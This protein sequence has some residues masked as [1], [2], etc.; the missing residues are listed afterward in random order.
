M[1]VAY[2]HVTITRKKSETKELEALYKHRLVIWRKQPAIHRVETP[3]NLVRARTL[4]Y[5]AKQGFIMIRV[6]VRR[7]GL[8]RPRPRMGRRQT[9][10][11][12]T[13]YTPA[14][15]MRLIA[16]ERADKR[17]PNLEVLN[18]YWVGEDG[19]QKWFEVIMIDP[20]HPSIQRDPSVRW[21][22]YNKHKGRASRGLTSA[23]KKI[24]GS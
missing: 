18:S 24:R 19:Q 8:R 17:F 13:R 4:G 20:H 14:K 7:G 11:G 16:E 23:G 6:R 5:K 10:M 12:V 1:I 9:H 22:G 15:S 3:L 2:K 21:I